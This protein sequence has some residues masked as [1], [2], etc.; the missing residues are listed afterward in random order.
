[1]SRAKPDERPDIANG[2]MHLSDTKTNLKS[3]TALVHDN[4]LFP[5]LAVTLAKSFGK[6]S[7]ADCT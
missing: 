1:M 3:K 5:W 2:E 4:G 6:H 7:A